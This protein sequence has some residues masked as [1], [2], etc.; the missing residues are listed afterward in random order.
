L[1]QITLDERNMKE[2]CFSFE[3]MIRQVIFSAFHFLRVIVLYL[4]FNV[5]Q[6][7]SLQ[8]K[9]NLLLYA[10]TAVFWKQ[11]FDQVIFE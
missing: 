6:T 7:V 3:K 4:Y 5:L 9:Q 1:V 11:N 2:I 10:K 8:S